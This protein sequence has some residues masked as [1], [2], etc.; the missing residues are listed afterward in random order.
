[1]LKWRQ[2]SGFWRKIKCPPVELWLNMVGEPY[3]MV[4][5]GEQ[6]QRI[7]IT[8]VTNSRKEMGQ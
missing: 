8:T 1:M 3:V 2:R 5:E 7:F 4:G 6:A